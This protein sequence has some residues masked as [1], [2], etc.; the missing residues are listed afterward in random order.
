[1][2]CGRSDGAAFRRSIQK[3]SKI[4]GSEAT[5]VS[6]KK[7]T[8]PIASDITPPVDPMIVRPSDANEMRSAYCVAVKAGEH[9][10]EM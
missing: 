8:Q 9:K 3:S 5:V 7:G 1:M 2:G 10:L 6:R 4:D